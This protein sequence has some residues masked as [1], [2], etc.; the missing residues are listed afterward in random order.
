MQL[1]QH[2]TPPRLQLNPLHFKTVWYPQ[3]YIFSEHYAGLRRSSIID[4]R[5]SSGA[6]SAGACCAPNG[7]NRSFGSATPDLAF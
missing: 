4:I 3:V 2:L 5:D 7:P 6:S 1:A